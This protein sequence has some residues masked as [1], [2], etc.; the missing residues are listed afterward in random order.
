MDFHKGKLLRIKL[1]RSPSRWMYFRLAN[2]SQ[3]FFLWFQFTWRRH[4]LPESAYMEGWNA[5][6]RQFHNIESGRTQRA[7]DFAI[8]APE[9]HASLD[10]AGDRFCRMCGQPLSQ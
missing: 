1:H 2:A 7:L 5:A 6:F 4:W 3:L 10:E 9:Y 8:C